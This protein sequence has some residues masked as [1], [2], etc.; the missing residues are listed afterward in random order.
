MGLSVKYLLFKE[1][2]L[3]MLDKIGNLLAIAISA[4]FVGSPVFSWE[5]S[6]LNDDAGVKWVVSQKIGERGNNLAIVCAEKIYAFEITFTEPHADQ[7]EVFYSF[8]TNI[9]GDHTTNIGGDHTLFGYIHNNY[10]YGSVFL[11]AS[12]EGYP[13]P[14][15]L[16]LIDEMKYSNSI[17]FM[18]VVSFSPLDTWDLDGFSDSM[19][20]VEAEC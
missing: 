15:T 13:A 17:S 12:L 10:D 8:Q 14:G 4:I 6:V 19:R 16:S 18:S 11:A 9:G 2:V 5:S 3:K 20:F 1:K 7:K